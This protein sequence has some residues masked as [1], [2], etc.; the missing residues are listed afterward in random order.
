M[1]KL[2]LD[3]PP[4]IKRLKDWL[5]EL[6]F[7]KIGFL[8]SMSLTNDGGKE[9]DDDYRDKKEKLKNSDQEIAGERQATHRIIEGKG[10]RLLSDLSS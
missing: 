6:E 2:N 5:A 3:T 10:E 8:E 9:K 7:P 1:L 4:A